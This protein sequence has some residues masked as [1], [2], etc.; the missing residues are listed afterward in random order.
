MG[1]KN[2]PGQ[3]DCYEKA[4]PDEEM[5]VLLGRD[6]SGAALV[7]A[8]ARIREAG[9]E[10]PAVVAEAMEC[11]DKMDA[12]AEEQGKPLITV[13][14]AGWTTRSRDAVVPQKPLFL[15][16]RAGHYVGNSVLWWRPNGRGYTSSIEEA[17]RYSQEEA[18][19]FTGHTSDVAWPEDVILRVAKR[20]VDMQDL[21]KK[22]KVAS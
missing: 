12:W 4:H 14:L 5:F 10:D 8:W 21:A 17:G 16:Q 2:N 6:P 20:H 13:C 3:F 1:T 7:R 9:G 19:A 15:I 11:A 22:E 18:Q